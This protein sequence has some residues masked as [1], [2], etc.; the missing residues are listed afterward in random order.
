MDEVTR[1]YLRQRRAIGGRFVP[2]RDV[3]AGLIGLTL[4]LCLADQPSKMQSVV[5][6]LLGAIGG[7]AIVESFSFLWRFVFVAP[8]QLH[9]DQLT[10]ISRIE[11]ERDEALAALAE[12]RTSGPSPSVLLTY[13]APA[14]GRFQDVD[15]PNIPLG[16]HNQT[17]TAALGIAFGEVRLG[18]R[19][20]VQFDEIPFIGPYSHAVATVTVREQTDEGTWSVRKNGNFS[21]ALSRSALFAI[22]DGQDGPLRSPLLITYGDDKGR[23]YSRGYDIELDCKALTVR[24]VFRR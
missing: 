9:R 23:K 8:A 1:A 21:A 24:L 20:I 13:E 4:P 16:V 2:V 15:V 5:F 18:S 7:I 14:L 11:R 22:L 19:C 10:S 12:Q 3:V 6:A 17:G